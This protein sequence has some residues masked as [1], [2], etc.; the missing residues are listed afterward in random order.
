MGSGM[1]DTNE[2]GTTIRQA[3]VGDAAK[4][5]EVLI[6]SVHEVCGPDYGNDKEVLEQW[7][8]N[9]KPE[10]VGTWVA[11]P[12][13]YFLVAELSSAGVARTIVGAACYQRPQATVYLLYL[14]PEGLHHGIGSRLLRAMEDEALRLKHKEVLLNSSIT[15]RQFYKR[16][17]FIEAGE[18]VY[19]GKV[20]GFP[21]RKS[22]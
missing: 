7:C 13:N 8:S 17:G 10:I 14:V 18:P 20:L 4:V 22:L 11:N 3:V 16:H 2:N 15:A 12:D 21:M 19:M 9:K 6:R 5:C 1:V